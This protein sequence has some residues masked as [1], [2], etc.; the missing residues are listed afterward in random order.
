[1]RPWIFYLQQTLVAELA[2]VED[3]IGVRGHEAG[4]FLVRFAHVTGRDRDEAVAIVE[5]FEHAF[6]VDVRVEVGVLALRINIRK[7]W[8]F[9]FRTWLLI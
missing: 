8:I 4:S 3:G 7:W 9:N 2:Y 6:K 5:A 1:M